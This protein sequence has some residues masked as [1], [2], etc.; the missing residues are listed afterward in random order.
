MV[1]N[2]VFRKSFASRRSLTAKSRDKRKPSTQEK[3]AL[4]M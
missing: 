2:G 3:K 1:L 4:A